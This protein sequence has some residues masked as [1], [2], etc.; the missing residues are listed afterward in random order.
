MNRILARTLLVGAA[1]LLVAQFVGPKRTN[2]VS[3]PSRQ[4]T[5]KA[6][7]PAHVDAILTRS[8]RN[9]HSNETRWPWYSYVAPMSWSVIGHVNE[10]REHLNFSEWSHTSE[11]GADLLDSVCTEVRRNRM[12]LPSYTWI[13]RDAVLSEA[14]KKQLCRW[15]ADAADALLN[16]GGQ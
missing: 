8:C 11:E 13:H 1:A 2:P 3:D 12:P 7:I 6:A 14:D 15:T 5:R 9:C 16:A 10:G 4:L